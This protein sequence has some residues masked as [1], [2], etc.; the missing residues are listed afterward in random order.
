MAER[1][2]DKLL[3]IKTVGIRNGGTSQS[4][5]TAMKLP[6]MSLDILFKSYKIKKTTR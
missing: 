6:P 5:S 1:T 2:Y 4:A 3:S